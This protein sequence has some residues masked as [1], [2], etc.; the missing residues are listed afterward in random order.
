M[1]RG[2]PSQRTYAEGYIVRQ[3]ERTASR[4]VDG[5]AVV[6]LIDRQVLHTL[7]PVG[8]VIWELADGRTLGAIL[9]SIEEE[10]EID[11]ATALADAS[12]FLE[13]LETLGALRIEAADR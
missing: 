11:R 8:T 5:K 12:R 2:T 4:V 1:S 13:E 3:C 9:D 6:V 7:N 10:F